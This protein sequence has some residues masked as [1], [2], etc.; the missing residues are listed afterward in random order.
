MFDWLVPYARMFTR[1]LSSPLL[2]VVDLYLTLGSFLGSWLISLRGVLD[3][4]PSKDVARVLGP[5]LYQGPGGSM[6]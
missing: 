5:D 6:S 1:Y 3:L 4:Y 2:G